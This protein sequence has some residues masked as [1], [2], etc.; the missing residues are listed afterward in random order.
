MP[1]VATSCILRIL[2]ITHVQLVTI[3]ASRLPRIGSGPIPHQ[4]FDVAWVSPPPT[5]DS[6]R[7]ALRGTVPT[8]SSYVT[9]LVNL[10]RNLHRIPSPPLSVP[11]GGVRFGYYSIIKVPRPNGSWKNHTGG[12]SG[13]EKSPT[14]L[15]SPTSEGAYELR[16]HPRC[17]VSLQSL[18]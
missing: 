4:W 18:R 6:S 12:V 10:C 16:P 5:P 13:V 9:F 17:P 1:Y 3:P 2:M 11:P 15:M 7:G 14:G 8:P